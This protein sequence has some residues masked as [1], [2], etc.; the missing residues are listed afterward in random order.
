[1]SL[2][3]IYEMLCS[4]LQRRKLLVLSPVVCVG[5]KNLT[6]IAEHFFTVL[7]E[8]VSNAYKHRNNND[9]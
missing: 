2:S 9:I 6:E 3:G 8:T 5:Y 7:R 4:I 1:M